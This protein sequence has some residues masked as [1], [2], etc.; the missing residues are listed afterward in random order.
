MRYFIRLLIGFHFILIAHAQTVNRLTV[1]ENN[2]K[3]MKNDMKT[4]DL[5]SFPFSGTLFKSLTLNLILP[6][7]K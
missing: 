2:I 4:L 3:I 6:N 1:I 5:I 7:L